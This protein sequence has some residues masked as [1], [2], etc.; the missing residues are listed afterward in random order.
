MITEQDQQ[1]SAGNMPERLASLIGAD[2]V[3]KPSLSVE[4]LDARWER[5]ETPI[6]FEL[7]DGKAPES[8][9]LFRAG[10]NT[11]V[12]GTFLFD[13]EAATSVIALWIE[14]GNDLMMDYEHMS[15]VKPPIIAPAS[16]KK[17]TLEV[18]NG[19]LWAVGCQWT[20]RAR[21]ML[22]AGEYRFFSP[23]F[24]FD[25]ETGRIYYL[26]N[27]ALTNNPALNAA[28]PLMAASAS[29]DDTTPRD[30][31]MAL[32]KMACTGCKATL[33]AANEEGEGGDDAFCTMCLS[34]AKEGATGRKILSVLGLS[35]D[36]GEP[37]LLSSVESVARFRTEAMALTGQATLPAALG[38]LQGWKEK[39]AERDKFA[40][41]LAELEQVQLAA[42]FTQAVDAKVAAKH[43]SPAKAT[44]II[45]KAKS[46]DGRFE[47]DR[48]ELALGFLSAFE[49][50]IAS[51]TEVAQS[52]AGLAIDA[53]ERA[54]ALKMGKDPEEY[55]KWKAQAMLS[56]LIG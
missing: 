54:M 42:S 18:R 19:E 29:A 11:S 7:A 41:Q 15:L 34:T 5:I 55:A 35:L 22:E 24:H 52:A 3:I 4:A 27:C 53:Q 17:F 38:T 12:K 44:E 10:L 28:R 1:R 33:K 30:P 46:K 49:A 9:R 56:G 37:T 14:R 43:L 2:G 40:G 36:M 39:A 13:E 51:G 48:V 23:A 6:A 16:C 45:A 26:I 31:D 20:D 32:K 21:A 50:P 8:F 47:K 25:P